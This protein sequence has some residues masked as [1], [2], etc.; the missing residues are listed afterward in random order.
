MFSAL[1]EFHKID[2]NKRPALECCSLKN[3]ATLLARKST[4]FQLKC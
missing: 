1:V 2:S 3:L 4:N